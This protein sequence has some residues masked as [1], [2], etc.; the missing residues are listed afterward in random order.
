VKDGVDL[1]SIGFGFVE[2]DDAVVSVQHLAKI[3][4]LQFGYEAARERK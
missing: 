1:Y 3:G 4:R 2:I